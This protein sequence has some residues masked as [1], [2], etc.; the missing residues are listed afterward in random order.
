MPS[1]FVSSNGFFTLP[2]MGSYNGDMNELYKVLNEGIT[3]INVASVLN[4]VQN[5]SLAIH[6]QRSKQG[7]NSNSQY[8]IQIQPDKLNKLKFRIG[9]GNGTGV[10]YTDWVSFIA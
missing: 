2:I 10:S 4:G 3:V 9:T 7:D 1:T 5:Y 8:I 6:V